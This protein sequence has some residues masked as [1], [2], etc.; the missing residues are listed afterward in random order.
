MAKK[1]PNYSSSGGG[2]VSFIL[3]SILSIAC[4]VGACVLMFFKWLTVSIKPLILSFEQSYSLLEV[5]NVFVELQDYLKTLLADVNEMLA[6]VDLQPFDGFSLTQLNVAENV[7]LGLLVAMFVIIAL[8]AVYLLLVLM[9]NTAS[10]PMG[11]IVGILTM[12]LALS[13]LALLYYANMQINDA[14]SIWN[15]TLTELQNDLISLDTLKI[16][17]SQVFQWTIFPW[18]TAALG[19]LEAIFAR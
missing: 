3:C 1:K 7:T 13:A 16:D 17:A 12:L 5:H 15:D 18:I 2:A 19:F 11:V 9:G 8:Q 14:L 6:L 4:G 10:R